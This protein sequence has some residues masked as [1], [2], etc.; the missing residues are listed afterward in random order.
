MIPSR[1]SSAS[2]E[3]DAV[4][5]LIVDILSEKVAPL[6]F[7]LRILCFEFTNE[8]P[9]SINRVSAGPPPPTWFSTLVR[10]ISGGWKGCE[11]LAREVLEPIG[12]MC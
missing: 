4:P 3:G 7:L 10:S 11:P 5:Q 1:F 8:C 2:L 6:E 9:T 12:V